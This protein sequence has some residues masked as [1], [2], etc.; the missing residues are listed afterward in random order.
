M[1]LGV[2]NGSLGRRS[3]FLSVPSLVLPSVVRAHSEGERKAEGLERDVER[4][5]LGEFGA[6]LGR[7]GVRGEN[8]QTLT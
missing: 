6:L 7:E 8:G 1:L 5:T 2:E 4:D 3:T